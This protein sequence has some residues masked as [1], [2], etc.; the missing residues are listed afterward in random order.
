MMT[1][2]HQIFELCCAI[3]L[4]EFWKN[5]FHNCAN[6]KFP[7]GARYDAKNGNIT[8]K[9]SNQTGKITQESFHL[10]SEPIENIRDETM[11]IFK[12]KLGLYSPFDLR[13]KK[14]EIEKLQ[15]EYKE[16]INCDWKKLKPR[17]VK[18][19]MLMNYVIALKNKHALSS[20]ETKDVLENINL[21]F[22]YKRLLP[23]DVEYVD[24]K[25]Q[26]I[27]CFLFDEETRKCVFSRP[28]T[29]HAKKDKKAQPQKFE[30]AFT[31]YI[32]DKNKLA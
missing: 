10:P 12:E 28:H 20:K 17:S 27:Q 26:N 13:I 14:L 29:Y 23:D 6:N 5:I 22:Q 3:S 24:Y 19:T 11:M 18:D 30:Q 16:S 32:K 4:D 21:G 7:K 1:T 31:N 15:D 25:V 2:T 8:I 9:H